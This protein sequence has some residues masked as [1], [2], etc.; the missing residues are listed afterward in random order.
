MSEEGKPGVLKVYEVEEDQ[1]VVAI[2]NQSRL[3]KCLALSPNGDYLAVGYRKRIGGD[4][5]A[6]IKI[7]EVS[8]GQEYRTFLGHTNTVTS[9]AFSLD[10]KWLA[11]A[12][13]DET[14]R[15][16]S[17]ATGEELHVLR[18]H[19]DKVQSVC[20]SPD[21]RRLASAGED[22][23]VKLW[24]TATGLEAL[25]LLGHARTVMRVVFSPDGTQLASGSSDQTVKLWE[26]PTQ[27]R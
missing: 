19:T 11:S 2:G 6:E 7:W 20:F 8:S 16:W 5:S 27:A 1:E 17:C 18:G 10:G 13:F 3:I 23:T 9:V 26:S 22:Y 12:S 25:S 15:V 14:V 21:G 4:W 24:D